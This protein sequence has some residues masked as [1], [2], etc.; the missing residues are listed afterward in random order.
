ML[1]LISVRPDDIRSTASAAG[2]N[3]SLVPSG[4]LAGRANVRNAFVVTGCCGDAAKHVPCYVR[5]S[6]NTGG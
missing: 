4:G 3:S 1:P 5:L 6:K 2:F